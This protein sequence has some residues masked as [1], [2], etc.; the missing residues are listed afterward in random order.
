VKTPLRQ[1]RGFALMMA[2]MVIALMTFMV[3]GAISFTGSERTAAVLQT[4]AESMSACTQAARNLFLSRVRAL[5]GNIAAVTVDAGFPMGDNL[6]NVQ[7]R[8]YTGSDVTLKMVTRLPDAAMGGSRRIARDLSNTVGKSSV[9]AGYFSII[10]L[11]QDP[12]GSGGGPEQEVEFVVRVG[13]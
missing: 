9:L 3:V 12:D 2:M 7:S 11:C 1:E 4:R 6:L 13:L 5:Q 8:H 10:A